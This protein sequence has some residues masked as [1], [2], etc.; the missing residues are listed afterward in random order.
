MTAKDPKAIRIAPKKQGSTLSAAQKRFNNL[1]KQIDKNKKLLLD[2][3]DTI[4]VYQQKVGQ[5]YEPLFDTFNG[6]RLEWLQ[7][8][9]QYYEQP[10]FK[11]TDKAK[12][13]HIISA[14]CDDLVVDMESEAVKALFNKYKDTDYDAMV[15][16]QEQAMAEMIKGLAKEMF[17]VDID[18]D[19]DVSTPEKF[20]AHLQDKLREQAEAEEAVK[21]AKPKKK[22][23]KQL[24]REAKQQEDEALAGKS[25]QEIYRKLVAALHPD[26]EPDEQ[27]RAR[28]TELMQRVNTAYG[29]KDLL[30][31][32]ELQLEAEQVD[33]AQLG[34]IADD[35]LKHFNKILGEQLAELTEEIGHIEMTFME[36]LNM[37]FFGKIT[38]KHLLAELAHDMR[39]VKQDIAYIKEDLQD[40]A[41]PA[42]FKAW[43]KAYRIPK[44]KRRDAFDE[45]FGG[46]PF[47]FR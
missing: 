6:Y 15:Q 25:V 8:L 30:Q 24:A 35:R 27:E 17:K 19:V 31:L 7:L 29:K 23:V 12:I 10:Q 4:P 45:L 38:P 34:H 37:P 44:P 22:T 47:D 3:K 20:Q 1:I 13:K 14:V 2:W 33:A 32:L 26:R 42:T 41:D 16:E 5:E 40:H 46:D 36:R 21:A 9:D 39:Q 43:L 11:K 18:D 28:K